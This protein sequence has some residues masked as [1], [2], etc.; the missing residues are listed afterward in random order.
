MNLSVIESWVRAAGGL[1]ALTGLV[2]IFSGILRGITKSPGRVSGS[3]HRWLRSPLFY[4]LASVFFFGICY[5][6]WKPVPLTLSLDGQVAALVVGG[7]LY[8]PGMG[9]VLWGRLALGS[10]YFV[11]TGFEAQLFADHHLVSY[12]PYRLVRHPMYAGMI[13][14]ALGGLL[15]YRT[16][17]LVF[18]VVCSFGL[19]L[20]ARREEAALAAEFGTQW[21]DYC[22]RVPAFLPRLK[23][24]G[25]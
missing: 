8:F 15:I 18:L 11:S 21:V 5:L 7:L 9:F 23:D 17:T 12:G 25:D 20:R 22:R 19:V 6:L 24:D 13:A 3:T 4:L 2:T 10:M 1:T 16:W 14:A